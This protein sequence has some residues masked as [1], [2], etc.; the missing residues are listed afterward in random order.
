MEIVSKIV[1]YVVDF[2][3]F[4]LLRAA[5]LFVAAPVLTL[6]MSPVLAYWTVFFGVIYLVYFNRGGTRLYNVVREFITH[7]I[8][9]AVTFVFGG[10]TYAGTQYA[11]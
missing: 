3:M 11:R 5:V 8:M 9:K 1:R 4:T 2:V 10:N 7:G 6:V